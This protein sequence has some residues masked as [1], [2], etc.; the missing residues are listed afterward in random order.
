MPSWRDQASAQ[1]QE[2]LD[3][4]LDAALSTAEQALRDR[5]EFYPFAV[6]RTADGRTALVGADVTEEHPDAETVIAELWGVLQDQ[7]VDLRAAGVVSDRVLDGSDQVAVLLEHEEGTALEVTLGYE[8]DGRSFVAG[9]LTAGPG[10][11][12]VW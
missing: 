3:A 6:V 2:D 11:S 10:L 8:L 9:A 7:R 1:A 4:V 5:G 12:R